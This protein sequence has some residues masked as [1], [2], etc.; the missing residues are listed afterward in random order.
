[1]KKRKFRGKDIFKKILE[2]EDMSFQSVKELYVGVS[3]L[4][5][6]ASQSAQNHNILGHW[7]ERKILKPPQFPKNQELE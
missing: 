2:Q 6:N 4:K 7:D 1:M 5:T 3:I